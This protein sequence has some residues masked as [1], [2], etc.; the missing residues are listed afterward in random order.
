[1][2]IGYYHQ[3][4]FGGGTYYKL[5]KQ[6][7]EEYYKF[8]YCHQ[9]VPNYIPKAEEFIKKYE[10]LNVVGERFEE[11]FDG[12]IVEIY[13]DNNSEIKSIIE[14]LNNADWRDI[15][16]KEY[17]ANTLD[18]VCWKFYIENDFGTNYMI[19]GYSVYPKEIETIFKTFNEMKEKYIGNVELN[20]KD[21]ENILRHK[22]SNLSF[23]KHMAKKGMLGYTKEDVKKQKEKYKDYEKQLKKI[24]NN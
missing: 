4:F 3:V 9:A 19:D 11:Y 20:K 13:L 22:K 1:M 23:A 6:E 15:S 21:L 2:I 24:Q 18:D 8:E 17:T 14:I 7:G 10:T 5:S 12:K 16:K